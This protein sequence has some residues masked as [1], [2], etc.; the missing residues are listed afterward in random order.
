MTTA[1]N[2]NNQP[3]RPI[4]RSG[5]I[6]SNP[7][8]ENRD[9][10]KDDTNPNENNSPDI[11]DENKETY[12]G[13]TVNENNNKDD[14][15]DETNIYSISGFEDERVDDGPFDDEDANDFDDQGDEEFETF[16][17]FRAIDLERYIF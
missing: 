13:V 11:L 1:G 10:W 7:N 9:V 6:M 16:V 5:G 17:N 2:W 8:R 12:E 14:L 4:D 3:G 15:G